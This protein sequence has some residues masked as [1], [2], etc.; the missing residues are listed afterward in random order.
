MSEINFQKIENNLIES[1][2]FVEE[3]AAQAKDAF[4]EAVNQLSGVKR[5]ATHKVSRIHGL[6]DRAVNVLES[7]PEECRNDIG[8]NLVVLKAGS[9]G[10]FITCSK[11]L[12][13]G[14]DIAEVGFTTVGLVFDVIDIGRDVTMGFTGCLASLWPWRIIECVYDRFTTTYDD[15]KQAIS[16]VENYGHTIKD[17]AHNASVLISY[18]W[19]GNTVQS[20]VVAA[21]TPL[22]RCAGQPVPHDLYKL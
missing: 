14:E 3:K 18:C 1:A 19:N 22:H 21:M 8:K 7:S 16:D 6:F 13:A 5:D 15:I 4:K 10:S 9:V 20:D 17:Y 12:E 11:L 2:G